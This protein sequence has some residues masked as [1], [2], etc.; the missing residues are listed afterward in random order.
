[1]KPHIIAYL[2]SQEILRII[3]TEA[4]STLDLAEQLALMGLE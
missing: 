4:S 2:E 1:M 3:P